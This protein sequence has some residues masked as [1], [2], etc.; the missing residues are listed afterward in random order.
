[1]CWCI[2]FSNMGLE[3]CSNTWY[4]SDPGQVIILS[5]P[6]LWFLNLWNEQKKYIH[7]TG[8][9]V[10]YYVQHTCG[11]EPVGVNAF[12]QINSWEL[13]PGWEMTVNQADPVPSIAP[14]GKNK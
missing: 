14:L 4:L 8:G 7:V 9:I 1:M 12:F 10:K 13:S 3:P 5:L 6:E 2:L 11:T